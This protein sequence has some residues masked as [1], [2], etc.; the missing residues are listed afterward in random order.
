M[1]RILVERLNSRYLDCASKEE[2]SKTVVSNE[3]IKLCKI[4]FVA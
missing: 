2:V 3:T 1:S 4:L